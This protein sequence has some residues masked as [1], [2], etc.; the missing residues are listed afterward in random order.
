MK[1]FFSF[2]AAVLFAGSMMASEAIMQYTGGVTTNM[3]GDGA[4]NAATVGLD[5]DLFTVLADKGANQNL[6]G[7]NKGNDIR[8]YADRS[9]GNGNT[10]TV[11]IANGTINSI[12]LDIK[13]TATFVVKAGETAVTE[14]G[15]AYAIN[16]TS[17]SIQNTTTGA[18]TQL[19]LNKITITYTAEGGETPVEPGDEPSVLQAVSDSTT[20][21]FSKITA[22]T[23]NALYGN[24]GIKLT[25]ESTP[26]KNDE[27][28]YA[29]YSADFMTIGEDFN[30]AA[31]AFKGEYPIRKNQYCQAGTLHFKADVAGTI[32]VKFSDTGSSASATAVK[33]YLVV[34]GEQ[35]EYW[36]S[37]ENNGE[38]PYDAQLN[39]VSG[40]IAVPAGDVTITGSSAITMYYVTFVPEKAVEP[41]GP[42]NLGA[43]TIA[44]FLELKNTTDTCILTGVV[45]NIQNTTY[46]NFDLT[47]ESGKVYVYGLLT[48]AGESKKFAELNVAENDTLTVL[49]I[50]NEHNG[51]PQAKNAIFVEV[52]KSTAPVVEPEGPKNLGAKTIAEF[53]ELKNTTDT[54][55]LTGVV[56]NIQNTTYGNFDL[57]DESGKVYVYGLLTPA[58]ESKKFAELNVAE[59]DT[60][61]VLA[62]YNEYNGN[63][64]AKN[65]IFVE[66]KKNSAPVV[67]PVNLGAKTIAEFL[68][69]KNTKDTC[70]LTGVVS[71][72]VNTTYGN[73]DLTDESG[74]VYVYGLLTPEGESKKFA[75][76]NVAENDTLTVLAIYNE[77]NGTPQA[78]NA[79]FVE[80]KKAAVEPGDTIELVFTAGGVDN[81]YYDTY[82]STDIQLY[83]IPVVGGQ[84]QGD[85][86]F[87]QLEIYPADPND[88]SGEYSIEDEGLDGYYTYLMHIEGTDTTEIE[89]VDGSITVSVQNADKETSSADLTVQG[90]LTT[91]EGD[92]YVINTT[93]NVYYNFALTEEEK[94]QNDEEEAEFNYNFDSYQL[95][96]LNEVV[97]GVMAQT[98]EAGI[99]LAIILPEGQTELT[100]GT[101]EISVTPM[102]GTV[103]AGQ[104]TEMGMSPSYA[105]TADEKLWF[106]V[107]G[108]VTVNEDG[109]IVVDALN[110]NGKAVKSTLNH[111]RGEGIDEVN[112]AKKAVKYIENG[113]LIIEKAGVRY[114]AA[115]QVI[116]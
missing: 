41:E 93:L 71:N 91:A 66:V 108:T 61:T 75:D 11:R 109:S 33:R 67:E 86:D 94:Y 76:L 40:K 84:L 78:K 60:L 38:T 68:E 77:Y 8:L 90:Q 80:V 16:A 46:G 21:D 35:T 88:I 85:G 4:N 59:N 53:L 28:I 2:L 104:N 113:Q 62:I 14:A 106:L 7:L 64:Q 36:T 6:P 31:I 70:I 114:N 50:Y 92:V 30:K 99:A 115:G 19:H 55:I 87:L 74:T 100:A 26:S 24:D 56:S 1:K 116:R 102:Y 48:P 20:W 63:P 73:F 97:V 47:D 32:V 110:S 29:D 51:N 43:K 52:K 107:S 103:M 12:V 54:C 79:I 13:Q 18:T 83:N 65:A 3:V 15:G 25:D 34:N 9:T 10:I 95:G 72:I 45:S 96:A 44:E 23:A 39:V 37:R 58:G 82:G 112:A 69:L 17:F 49:A 27:V 42:K 98:D 105:M 5:A 57:T 22:N 111:L 101:Y 81:Y 89:F